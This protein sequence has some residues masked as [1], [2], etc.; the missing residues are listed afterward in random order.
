MPWEIYIIGSQ[1][2]TSNLNREVRGWN[3]GSGSNFCLEI[4]FT[5]SLNIIRMVC[6]GVELTNSWLMQIEVKCRMHKGSPKIP[7]LELNQP[8][9]SYLYLSL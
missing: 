1:E 3:P 9:Y 7:I 5:L 4:W 8:N 6:I 2:K